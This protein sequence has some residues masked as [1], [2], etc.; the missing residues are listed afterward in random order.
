[1]IGISHQALLRYR[2]GERRMQPDVAHRALRALQAHPDPRQQV[3]DRLATPPGRSARA[4]R[5]QLPAR[6]RPVL[7]EMLAGAELVERS[8]AIVLNGRRCVRRILVPRSSG[9][10]GGLERS[11]PVAIA[12]AEL[13]AARRVTD[14]PLTTL[15]QHVGV[16]QSTWRSWEARGVPRARVEQVAESLAPPA[17]REMRRL[18]EAAGWSLAELGER[19]GVSFSVVQAWE[20]AKRP[21]PPG[22][23][24]PLLAALS[25]AKNLA[26]ERFERLIGRVVE[27]VRAQ[28]GVSEKT[29][30]H[31]HRRRGGRVSLLGDYAE[32]LKEAKARRLIVESDVVTKSEAGPKSRLGLFVRGSAPKPV[33]PMT[34][35]K[36]RRRREAIGVSRPELALRCNVS[37]PA[38]L[39][40][41]GRGDGA[42]PAHGA[43]RARAAL[44]ALER[45]ATQSAAELEAHRQAEI[46]AAVLTAI[47]AEPGIVTTRLLERPGL[48]YHASLTARL[49]RL[50]AAGEIVGAPVLDARGRP[51]RGWHLP[52]DVPPPLETL[53]G[54]ELRRLREEAGWS[55]PALARAIGVATSRLY[56]WERGDRRCPF[57]RAAVVR[58]LLA[59][60]PPLPPRDERALRDLEE[61]AAVPGGASAT[62]LGWPQ[63]RRL[64]GLALELGRLKEAHVDVMEPSGRWYRRRRFFPAGTPV[65]SAQ[66]PSLAPNEL[67]ALR[68]SVRLSQ[69]ALGEIL[70]VSHVTVSG[71][72]CGRAAIPPRHVERLRALSRGAPNEALAPPSSTATEHEQP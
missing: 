10:A 17:P 49:R 11:A 15:A 43:L 27:D 66:R 33:P 2:S 18:R 19:L 30:L 54:A 3:V 57:A 28:P 56:Q 4:A 65:V 48:G 59:T 35:E 31:D 41:E 14:R 62:A 39:A 70:G 13:R 42:I 20:S 34:G 40:W 5:R 29:L 53:S 21:V 46:D 60:P 26:A 25:E 55:R 71:W 51:H 44:D 7:D 32:A 8:E 37:L 22:R 45:E 6:L 38:L 1:M 58:S 67:V 50:E 24:V 63:R 12:G 52:A 9:S 69:K 61:Q 68:R 16:T 36:L 72:E 23:L 64:I 47:A